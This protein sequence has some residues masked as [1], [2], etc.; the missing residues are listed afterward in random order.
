MIA[1]MTLIRHAVDDV[2]VESMNLSTHS[3][4]DMLRAYF[5]QAVQHGRMMSWDGTRGALSLV[6][7]RSLMHRLSF[8]AYW[9]AERDGK[10]MHTDIAAWLSAAD[11]EPPRLDEVARQL[12][13]PGMSNVR[14]DGL[15]D[16]WLRRSHA[17]LQAFSD[18][19]AINSYLVALRLFAV[20]GELNPHDGQRVVR[21]LRDQLGGRSD[22]HLTAFLAAWGGD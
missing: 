4:S 5:S 10:D 3:E 11:G 17:D 7:F 22:A 2:R 20:T 1:S 12:G 14:A 19:N 21:R 9:Q 8:P 6:R 13:L 15:S 16:A 18:L